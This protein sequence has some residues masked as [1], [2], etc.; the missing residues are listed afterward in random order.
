MFE[1]L[2]GK[3]PW[4]IMKIF[5]PKSPKGFLLII[6]WCCVNVK[7]VYSLKILSCYVTFNYNSSIFSIMCICS[8]TWILLSRENYW[9][10]ITLLR[11]YVIS[12]MSVSVFFI[13]YVIVWFVKYRNA[14]LSEIAVRNQSSVWFV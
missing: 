13:S 14:T 7:Q 3:H 5:S 2:P 9:Y 12:S 1:K 6:Y 4:R 10:I 11:C 8:E